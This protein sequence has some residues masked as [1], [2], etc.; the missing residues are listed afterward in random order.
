MKFKFKA[1]VTYL[2]ALAASIQ[3][4]FAYTLYQGLLPAHSPL[5]LFIQ[6]GCNLTMLIGGFLLGWRETDPLPQIDPRA[7]KGV[8]RQRFAQPRSLPGR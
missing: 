7:L 8:R 3:L 5:V 1:I 2:T 6:I 4:A